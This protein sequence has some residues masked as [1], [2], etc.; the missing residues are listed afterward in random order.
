MTLSPGDHVDRYEVLSR[1][2]SGGMGEVFRARD[3]KLQREIALKIVRVDGEWG[4]EGRAR[5][6]RE[7]RAIAALSHPNVLSVYDV[8]EVSEPEALRGLP[9]IAMELVVGRSL[10]AFVGDA[11]VPIERRIGWL[12]DIARGLAAA[13]DAG[14]VH[15][16]VKPENVMVREDGVVKVLD[17]GIARKRLPGADVYSTNEGQSIPGQSEPSASAQVSQDVSTAP[18]VTVGT[19]FYMA[20]EQLRAESLDGRADQFAWGVVAYELLTGIAPWK[21]D[22]PFTV[23]ADLLTRDPPPPATVDP[24]IPAAASEAVV[25]ALSKDASARFPTMHDLLDALGEGGV[26]GSTVSPLAATRPMPSVAPAPPSVPRPVAPE[27][28]PRP[29]LAVTLG[30]G[31]VLAVSLFAVQRFVARSS[32]PPQP[33]ATA[34]GPSSNVG[35]SLAH[36]GGA[37]RY[38]EKRHA[39][40]EIASPDCK[41]LAAPGDTQR[42]DTVWIGGLFPMTGPEAA[43]Y[44]SELAA[45]DLARK[46]FADALVGSISREGSMHARPIAIV[47][48]DEAVDPLR[49]ARHLTEDVEVPAVVGFRWAKTAS[50]AIS[51][52][53]MPQH[54][55][56]MV[57]ISQTSAITQIPEPPGE[58]R[59]VW[60]STLDIGATAAPLAALVSDVLEPRVRAEGLGARPMR[61]ALVHWSTAGGEVAADLLRQLRFNGKSA[62]ENGDDL[63]RYIYDE[64]R[65]G[66]GDGA[67]EAL[68]DF[69]PQVVVF[70]GLQFPARVLAPLEARW[71]R[72]PRP[73][74]VTTTDFPDEI[75][76]FA[77]SDAARRRRFFAM[78]NVSLT[79]TNAQLVLH[80]NQAHP[81]APVTRTSAPQPSY[82]AFYVLAYAIHALGDGRVTGPAISDAIRRLEPPGRPID[83]GPAGIFE[84]FETLRAGG[85]I[86]LRGAIG[87][88]DFDRE[89]GEAPIDYAILCPGV[90]DRGTA[91]GSVE[92]GLVFESGPKKLTGKLHCP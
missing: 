17:F 5:L 37:W 40:V 70:W 12:K 20:P 50:T 16:D 55:L 78:T 9:Y 80:Y 43:D 28:K 7:A 91:Q 33:A 22:Q 23:V 57:S 21:G 68:L 25:R 27:R 38:S 34:A 63:R 87:S 6:L 56:S 8:G 48:C 71:S 82:D 36:G 64:D 85:G 89:T 45:F 60:R 77:G 44:A 24:R 67:V 46:D 79:M 84:A 47:A 4:T 58:P 15:R 14:L 19:P 76:T 29:S 31:A 3:P 72:G 39:C 30:I 42:E 92:S 54:V 73:I 74:Y 81:D 49:A 10:R 65:D 90:N 75:A 18:H 52:I 26:P 35:C 83:V 41:V 13:H 2:G 61:V 32:S 88:L 86:D 53:F 59:L 62:L 66:G 1:L 51:P 11:R 69:A